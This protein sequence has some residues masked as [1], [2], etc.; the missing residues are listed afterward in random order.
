M[1]NNYIYL[2]RVY[3]NRDENIYKIGKTK[4]NFWS[5]FCEYKMIQPNIEFVINCEDCNNAEEQ[6][7]TIF[8]DKFE[9]RF[10]LGNEYF[11]GS[12]SEMKS[13]LLTFFID[14]KPE[15]KPKR[16]ENNKT[17]RTLSFF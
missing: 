7:L 1:S 14:F 17:K 2:L 4:R 15:P 8:T 9:K 11:V 16:F 10:D 12:V 6:L 13:T 5:R 3:P